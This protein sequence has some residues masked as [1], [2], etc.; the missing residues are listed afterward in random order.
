MVTL[1]D[2]ITEIQI[3]TTLQFTDK[4]VVD[5]YNAVDTEAFR[6]PQEMEEDFVSEGSHTIIFDR[7][8]PNLL[9]SMVQY[10]GNEDALVDLFY[11]TEG[12]HISIHYLLENKMY[13][14]AIQS[15]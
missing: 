1:K 9:Q 5:I 12:T 7:S 8:I 10:K 13:G 6:T 4:Q 15:L 2:L 3:Y 14:M 11:S